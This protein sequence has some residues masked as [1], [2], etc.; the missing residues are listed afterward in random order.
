[1]V[2]GAYSDLLDLWSRNVTVREGVYSRRALKIPLWCKRWIGRGSDGQC[3]A[4]KQT[5]S[6][7]EYLLNSSGKLK[8]TAACLQVLGNA[9]ILAELYMAA[10]WERGLYTKR[11]NS[12]CALYAFVILGLYSNHNFKQVYS[13]HWDKNLSVKH[14]FLFVCLFFEPHQDFTSP[15]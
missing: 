15:Y 4:L 5:V 14:S 8:I 10:A 2:L 1:M 11:K 7:T 3:T 9:S 6:K 12:C 13:E